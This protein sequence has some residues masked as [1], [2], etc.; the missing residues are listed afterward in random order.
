MLPRRD[1]G[2]SRPCAGIGPHKI[3]V[4]ARTRTHVGGLRIRD[5]NHYST[6]PH[7]GYLFNMN[8]LL[9]THWPAR[10]NKY[11]KLTDDCHQPNSVAMD[12][13]WMHISTKLVLL[14]GAFSIVKHVVNNGRAEKQKILN[15]LIISCTLVYTVT[16]LLRVVMILIFLPFSHLS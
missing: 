11:S 13:P 15:R 8:L 16:P 3:M 14:S 7:T 4:A 5:V 1:D 10:I 9:G 2:S 6:T 12:A